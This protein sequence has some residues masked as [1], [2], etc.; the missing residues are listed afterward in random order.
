MV[1]PR[2]NSNG[3]LPGSSSSISLNESQTE[4]TNYDS[5]ISDDDHAIAEGD[6]EEEEEEEVDE[7]FELEVST[8]TGNRFSVT[9]HPTDTVEVLKT[10]IAFQEG[11][12]PADQNLLLEQGNKL[13]NATQS[14]QELNINRNSK[15]TLVT[16]VASGVPFK[17]Y[18]EVG[19]PLLSFSSSTSKFAPTIKRNY[20]HSHNHNSNVHQTNPQSSSIRLPKILTTNNINSH[21]PISMGNN[22]GIQMQA[23]SNRLDER[24]WMQS[25]FNKVV[26]QD[27]DDDEAL[28]DNID[29]DS[30]TYPA[31][32]TA[33]YPRIGKSNNGTLPVDEEDDSILIVQGDDGVILIIQKNTGPLLDDSFESGYDKNNNNN[34]K[35][36]G[37]DMDNM[38]SGNGRIQRMGGRYKSSTNSNSTRSYQSRRSQDTSVHDKI[39]ENA[40][41]LEKM[42]H[43]RG[44]MALKHPEKPP[45]EIPTRTLEFPKISDNPSLAGANNNFRRDSVADNRSFVYGGGG[46]RKDNRSATSRTNGMRSINSSKMSLNRLIAEIYLQSK[47]KGHSFQPGQPPYTEQQL[48]KYVQLKVAILLDEQKKQNTE[49]CSKCQLGGDWVFDV[50][51]PY[52]IPT[53]VMNRYKRLTNVR[54]VK[55]LDKE[56]TTN[57]SNKRGSQS[58]MRRSLIPVPGQNPTKSKE[59]PSRIISNSVDCGTIHHDNVD[60]DED[61]PELV[62]PVNNASSTF[63]T[64]SSSSGARRFSSSSGSTFLKLDIVDE[65][66]NSEFCDVSNHDYDDNYQYQHQRIANQHIYLSNHRPSY[67]IHPKMYSNGYGSKKSSRPA[68]SSKSGTGKKGVRCNVCKKKLGIA[69]RYQCRCGL[70]FCSVHR[71]PETHECSFDYKT[72]GRNKLRE[73]NPVIVAPKIQ[74]I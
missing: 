42:R 35:S 37:S 51:A 29:I 52:L 19:D 54:N 53:V 10:R 47:R 27:D 3:K 32:A 66:N 14:I 73:E 31:A 65:S 1:P 24:E 55:S 59:Y 67:K 62:H 61:S 28:G 43:I 45:S 5:D 69:C 74:N 12:S 17:Q 30:T 18:R 2:R 50:D 21:G 38:C 25:L 71:Y 72:E 4:E 60:Y 20:G 11:I 33:S 9:I 8:L 58:G 48:L 63:S 40:V 46:N 49:P 13:L 23:N 56:A 15:L 26:Q 6:D 44:M 57:I 22:R 70:T 36:R 68:S 41:T 16:N 7:G 64:K 39:K 34:N